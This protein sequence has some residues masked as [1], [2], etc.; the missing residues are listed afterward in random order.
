MFFIDEKE[1]YNSPY[2]KEHIECA[3]N[4]GLIQYA[5]KKHNIKTTGVCVYCGEKKE[6]VELVVEPFQQDV[7]NKCYVCEMCNAC[8]DECCDDI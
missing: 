7:N 2:Y 1:Y 3:Y 8:Y 6:D 4:Y 5:I